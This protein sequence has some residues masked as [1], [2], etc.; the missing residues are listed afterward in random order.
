[1]GS[2]NI[3]RYS[4]PPN[5]I[6][7]SAVKFIAEKYAEPITLKDAAEHLCVNYSYLSRIFKE[8]EG[9]SFTECL[10][11]TR[12]NHATTLLCHTNIT[13]T[14]IALSC[15]FG[16]VRNFNRLFSQKIQ[17]SPYDFRKKYTSVN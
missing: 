15:G 1:M 9:L 3:K 2:E 16:S 14:E 7:A 4:I 11:G 10:N 8:R 6:C 17:G 5:D 13:I 12:L